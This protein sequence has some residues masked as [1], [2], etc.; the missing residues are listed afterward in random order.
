M[1]LRPR[2]MPGGDLHHFWKPYAL[3]GQIDYVYGFP[4][5]ESRDGFPGA[6][7]FLN[8]IESALNFTY[9][10]YWARGEGAA[11]ALVGLISVVMTL[12]KTVL[13]LSIEYFSG[14]EHIGQ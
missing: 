6:Q 4:A 5:F 7:S 10:S 8:L 12:S 13:Y 1:L 14:W 2:S 3:Y 9:L 11:A